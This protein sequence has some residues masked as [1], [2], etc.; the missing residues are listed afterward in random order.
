VD[1]SARSCFPSEADLD[2]AFAASEME[3][4]STGDVRCDHACHHTTSRSLV[5]VSEKSGMMLAGGRFALT[6]R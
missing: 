1:P 5:D 6:M 2:D 3:M 4:R